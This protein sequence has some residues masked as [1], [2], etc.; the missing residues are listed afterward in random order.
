MPLR[1]VH[2]VPSIGEEAS[3]PSYSVPSLC[4]AL[5]VAGVDVAL[6][7]LA[8]GVPQM[9]SDISIETHPEWSGVFRRLGV[10]PELRRALRSE[11]KGASV[12]LHNHSLWM[13]P[14]VYPGIVIA[15][16]RSRLVTS[17]R[18]VLDPWAR[19]RSRWSKRIMMVL[20]QRRTLERTDCFHAT[21]N[22]EFESVRGAGLRAPVA[23]IPNG[24][25]VPPL[26]RETRPEARKLLFLGRLHPKKG[27]DLLLRAWAATAQQFPEWELH[28][29]G[30]DEG[31]YRQDLERLSSDL[32]GP[33]VVFRGPVY[34][35]EK[36]RELASAS[37]FVLPTHAENFGLAVAEA[38][39]SGVPAIVTRGAPW[40]GLELK[41]CGWWIEQGVD[42]LTACLRDALIRS[43]PELE[44]MGL[45]GREW[46]SREFSWTRMGEMMAKT[47][48]W[49][50]GGGT[51]PEWIRFD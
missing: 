22:S 10:S 8:R 26:V 25:D 9:W 33:R 19:R 12:I 7:V 31:A 46:M 41:R 40:Q 20:L 50:L 37:L 6:H 43:P 32:R 18:G 24:V 23:V 29:V 27:L 4:R 48:A 51:A 3:G 14:N 15:N 11:A 5:G 30:P 13:M 1:A 34:G 17:P 47:Y 21:S 44:S 35:A 2:I 45:R 36:W 39:A 28:I 16:T 38:L 49:L 42:S